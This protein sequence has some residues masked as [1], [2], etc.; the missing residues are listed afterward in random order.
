MIDICTT[1]VISDCTFRNSKTGGEWHPY[2]EYRHIYPDWHITR[3]RS[4]EASDYW[5][6]VLMK[7]NNEFAEA[8]VKE[9]EM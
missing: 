1:S 7:F 6:Y 8:Y 3:H 2:K 4:M 9:L 5:K